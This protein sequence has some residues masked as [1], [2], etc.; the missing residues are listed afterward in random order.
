[1]SKLPITIAVV[2]AGLVAILG[3]GSVLLAAIG[4]TNWQTFLTVAVFVF[5]AGLVAKLIR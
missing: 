5:I 2:G 4:N 1:M 3:A